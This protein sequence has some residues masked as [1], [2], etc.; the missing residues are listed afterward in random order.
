MA[1]RKRKKGA[2]RRTSSLGRAFSRDR[3]PFGILAKPARRKGLKYAAVVTALAAVLVAFALL[4]R[5]IR[6]GPSAPG[7]FFLV[8]LVDV[9]FWVEKSLTDRVVRIARARRD[10]PTVA[11][12]IA[13]SVQR[14]ITGQMAW[15]SD[16]KVR[17]ANDRLVV[18]GRWRRPLVS[19][20]VGGLVYYVDSTLTVLDYVPLPKLSIVEVALG[21]PVGTP[22]VGEV[23]RRDDLAAAAALLERM[24]RM[25]NLVSFPKPLLN[26]IKGIDVRNLDGRRNAADGHIVMYTE[27]RTQIIWGARLGAWQR[28]LEA[29]DEEKLAKLY[30]YY[31]VH[32]TLCGGARYIDLRPPQDCVLRPGERY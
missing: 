31:E 4:D 7:D 16:A 18:E 27:D 32:G 6:N 28:Y 17:I 22:R 11:D 25:E 30:H 23:F 19:F 12:D 13:R 10:D 15:L 26:E 29:P 14:C 8:E 2:A 9:P 3:G 24:H 21:E 20:D 5:Y 1:K